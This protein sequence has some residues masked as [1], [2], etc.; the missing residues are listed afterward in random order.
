[1]AEGDSKAL[2]IVRPEIQIAVAEEAAALLSKV[3]QIP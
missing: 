1:V 2:P 3:K